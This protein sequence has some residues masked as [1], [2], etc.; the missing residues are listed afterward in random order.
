MIERTQPAALR[1]PTK[2]PPINLNLINVHIIDPY[3]RFG[4]HIIIFLLQSIFY[5][6]LPI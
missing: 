5:F 1:G 2:A 6:N 4:I 3:T